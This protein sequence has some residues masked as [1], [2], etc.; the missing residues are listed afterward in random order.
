MSRQSPARQNAFLPETSKGL[1]QYNEASKVRKD[2]RGV[3]NVEAARGEA[4]SGRLCKTYTL[5]AAQAAATP[6]RKEG[7]Y[8]R[9][10]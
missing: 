9:N 8:I 1:P 6:R 7:S 3:G 4:V 5:R 10:L 2:Y